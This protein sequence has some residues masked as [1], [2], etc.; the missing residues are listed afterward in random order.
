MQ[1]KIF[2]HGKEFNWIATT[3]DRSFFPSP[4][5]PARLIVLS[6]ARWISSSEN[7]AI[8]CRQGGR[9]VSLLA[10]T[11]KWTRKTAMDNKAA[12]WK[13]IHWA[14]LQ[15][16]Q[17]NNRSVYST[18]TGR[19][20]GDGRA[21]SVY[22]RRDDYNLIFLLLTLLLLPLDQ[23]TICR[24]WWRWCVTSERMQ[25][26]KDVCAWAPINYRIYHFPHH[27]SLCI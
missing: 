25:T 12:T 16:N 8:L 7:S 5:I 13:R 20:N 14:Y 6:F 9:D 3:D 11:C 10:S 18:W 2:H 21:V 19:M 4:I 22:W 27:I 23:R 24:G 26:G 15:V 1:I 17:V